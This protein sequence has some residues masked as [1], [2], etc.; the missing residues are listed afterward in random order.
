MEAKPERCLSIFIQAIGSTVTQKKYKYELDRFMKWTGVTEYSD[1]LKADEKSIQR[2]LEDYLIYLKDICTPNYIPSRMAPVELFYMMNDINLNNKRLHKM[3]P[4]RTK[5]GGY[6]AYSREDVQSM[7][8]NTKKKRTRAII[9]F[10]ASTGC[11]VG[12]LPELK[13]KH[14]VNLEDDC[15]SVLCY[16]ESKEEYTTFMTPE[17]S[18]AFDDYLEERQ[19]ANERLTPES[20]AFR[21]DSRLASAPAESMATVTIRNALYI[22]LKDVA[23]TKTGTRYNI[24]TV[25]GLRKFFNV[26]LK[27]RPDCNLSKCEKMMG[28]SVTV[29]LDNHYA[30]F[31]TGKLFEEYKKAIP[32]LTISDTERQTLQIETKNKK[33]EELEEVK[34]EKKKQEMLIVDLKNEFEE[35]KKEAVT[36]IE[37]LIDDKI[38]SLPKDT[39][40]KEDASDN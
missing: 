1:L 14:I 4:T 7:L 31:T 19:Q 22:T 34:L 27:S 18:K 40:K 20:P 21:K 30:P 38:R 16:P 15:K 12:V 17:A 25:H 6:G 33:L 8:L 3:Y 5:K 11:R 9:L 35:Y 28:H 36:K 29:S 26:T 23:K 39:T 10:L 32:E 13:L 2:N 37:K 24:P